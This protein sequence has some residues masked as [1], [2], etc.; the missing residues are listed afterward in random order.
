[1]PYIHTRVNVPL[2]ESQEITL[3]TEWGK[4]IALLPG[5]SESWLMAGFEDNC[6]LYF[7]GSGEAPMAF[8]E[9]KIFG[10]AD[11]GDYERLTVRITEV[12][13][14]V[15]DISADHVYVKY[16]EVQYWGWNGRNF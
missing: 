10:S 4:A 7:K 1:M 6:H 8:V 12:L 2:T 15:L 9:V 16:E 3:K 14:Q 13:Q 5:K 11:G